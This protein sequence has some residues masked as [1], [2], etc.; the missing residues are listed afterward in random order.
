VPDLTLSSGVCASGR[1]H[2]V[3]MS[4]P[5]RALLTTV[6]ATGLLL[7]GLVPAP[8]GAQAAGIPIHVSCTDGT[9]V[10]EWDGLTYD[11]DGTCGVVVIAAD[12]TEV[13]IPSSRTVVV[14][15]EGNVV[16]AKPTDRLRVLG[17]HQRVDVV[18]VR[19]LHVASPGSVVTVDGLAE[20]VSVDKRRADLRAGQVSE[21]VVAG[22]GHDV[23]A[24]RGFTVRVTGS[25]ATLGFRRL[26]TLRV[27]G[28]DNA[29][30]VRRGRT[31]VS[32]TGERNT[33]RVRRRT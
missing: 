15:G 4:S 14:R 9:V 21:L 12:N 1:R 22:R 7:A 23:R 11:L 25:H 19:A 3:G 6:V 2:T 32:D 20:E 33:I 24:R 17:S 10:L 27:S 29:V 26:E 16:H 5:P 8:P 30:R 28:D 13:T 18:S 31:E